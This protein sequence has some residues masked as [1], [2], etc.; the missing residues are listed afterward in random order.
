MGLP[1]QAVANLANVGRCGQG[2][3]MPPGPHSI[4]LTA[5]W[6]VEL[7]HIRACVRDVLSLRHLPYD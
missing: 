1:K 4:R 5:I 3:V 6:N 2:V 7:T